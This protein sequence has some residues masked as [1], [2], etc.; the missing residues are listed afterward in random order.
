MRISF[1]LVTPLLRTTLMGL[2]LA[3]SLPALAQPVVRVDAEPSGLQPLTARVFGRVQALPDGSL[4]RQWPGTYAEAAFIGSEAYFRVGPGDVSLRL[5]VDGEAPIP[6]LKPAPGLYRVSVPRAAP[7]HRLRIDVA[8]EN[9]GGATSF[10]GFFVAAGGRPATLP[11]RAHQV[12]FIGDSHTVGY[13]NTSTK[14]ECSGDEVFASTDTSLGVAPQVAARFDADYQVNAISGRGVVRN[15][16]GGGG[17]PLPTAYPFVLFDKASVASDPSWRPQ[18]IVISLGTNDF[19]TPL[20]PGEKWARRE[21]L[22]ADFEA[23][24]AKFIQELHRQQPQAY[25]LLWAAGSDDSELATEARKV[26]KQ[27]QQ[28]GNA[29]VGFVAVPGLAASACHYHPSLADDQR[30]ALLLTRHLEAQ[31][32]GLGKPL[33]DTGASAAA[34]GSPAAPASQ[35]AAAG[36]QLVNDPRSATWSVYGATQTH[37]TLAQ[38]GPKGYP[39]TRVDVSAK[40]NPWEVGASTPLNKPIQAGD[41]ILVAVYL[42]APAL[43]DGESTR[44]T[45]FGLNETSAPYTS[46]ANSPAE[47]TNQWKVFYASGQATKPLVPGQA[48][49]GMHL[50]A[51]R[52]VLELG[53]VLVYDHGKADPAALPR[54]ASLLDEAG[55]APAPAKPV[56]QMINDWKSATTWFVYGASQRTETMAQGGPKDFPMTRVSVSVKGNPWEVGAGSPMS[57]P[58][59][60][61]DAVLV[62]VY[63]RAPQLKDGETTPVSYFGVNETSP[64]YTN[65]AK[66]SAEVTNQWKVYHAS[67]VA[68]K[69]FAADQVGVG[70]QLGAAQHVVDL[71]PVLVYNFGQNVDLA[72]LPR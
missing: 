46:F 18:A 70:L 47:V 50:A 16:N 67:G 33:A 9:Q 61:G 6:L 51:A 25:I 1:N 71:G 48:V 65:I 57:K 27:V 44:V 59:K 34:T 23:S 15:Y 2:A 42:R 69:A 32:P 72:K 30:I 55:A 26:V 43:K 4:R 66:G 10:G 41:A 14:R 52:H 68:S 19:S 35:A 37:E 11:A 17:E 56:G 31:V 22:Q 62:S 13:A 60:A 38:G 7:S 8:S 45:Y 3:G 53:P 39:M 20:N 58:I 49:V 28:S 54:P 5:R 63:L 64:P 40:G 29:R 21:Q 36:A 12:E 24:Y